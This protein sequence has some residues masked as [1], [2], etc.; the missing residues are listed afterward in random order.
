MSL[1]INQNITALNA[2]RNLSKTDREMSGTMEKLSSGLR[3]NRAADDPSGLIISEQMRAQVVGLK[4]AVKN[5]EKGISMIQTA[6]AALD[7]MHSLLGKMRALALDSANSATADENMLAANQA[8][9]DNILDTITR[10]AENT[11][12]GTKTLL[13]GTNA[14]TAT[15]LSADGTGV[16]STNVVKSTLDTGVYNL[17]ITEDSPGTADIALGTTTAVTFG[18][19]TGTAQVASDSL[20]EAIHTLVLTDVTAAGVTDTAGGSNTGTAVFADAGAY[21]GTTD[22]TYIVR[23]ATGGSL[24]AA[25]PP[26]MDFEVS[27]DGGATYSALTDDGTYASGEAI[28]VGDGLTFSLTGAD[29]TTVV[30][31]DT[32]TL[33]ATAASITASLDGG[34]AQQVY[35]TDWTDVELTSGLADGGSAYFDLSGATNGT[36]TIDVTKTT[37]DATLSN[38]EAGTSGTEISG[39]NASEGAQTFDDGNGGELTVNMQDLT[40]AGTVQFD[41]TDNSLVFQV[42]ANQGQTTKIAIADVSVDQLALNIVN[43]SGFSNLGEIDIG[44][45]DPSAK[46]SDAIGLIDNAIDQVS[47]IRGDLGAFQANTL[48]ANLDSRRVS[49]ENLQASES[50]IRDTDMAAEMAD[51]TK[52]QIM[53]QAGTAML[54]QANQMPNNLLTLLR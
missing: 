54:A 15:V 27:T 7:K 5:S 1:M 10:I 36:A 39:F 53:L 44:E 51:F 47:V 14:N 19:T 13:D 3:I 50:I 12:Y 29:A 26:D 23:V 25:S 11:Q 24:L 22:Q 48:E 40:A 21:T 52:Y 32:W 33:D 49:A 4:A 8:E 16:I 41:N 42:G 46:A 20:S 35:A 2:W 28:T 30:A 38:V 45:P 43:D 34:V 37:Y 18:A 6:E 17:T 9:I 31:G